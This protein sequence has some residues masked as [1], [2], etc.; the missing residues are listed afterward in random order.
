MVVTTITRAQ[1]EQLN[2][3]LTATLA[4]N[5]WQYFQRHFTSRVKVK[6]LLGTNLYFL[7]NPNYICLWVCRLDVM[8]ISAKMHLDPSL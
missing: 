3:L 2:L 5:S 4:M 7:P 8:A 1:P 6:V